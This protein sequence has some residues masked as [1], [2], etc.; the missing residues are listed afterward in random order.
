V[1]LPAALAAWTVAGGPSLVAGIA[2][3]LALAGLAFY[4]DGYIRA[5]QSI[6]QS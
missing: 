6:P 5:G 1:A 2:A 4:E 3:V